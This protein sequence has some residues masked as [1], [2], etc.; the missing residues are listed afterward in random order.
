LAEKIALTA[1]PPSYLVVPSKMNPIGEEGNI[2]SNLFD[3]VPAKRAGSEEDIAGAVI[4]LASRAGVSKQATSGLVHANYYNRHILMGYL[5]ALTVGVFSL[6]MASN[7][8]GTC[9]AARI[10][11]ASIFLS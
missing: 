5:F 7:E 3:Q 1:L 11:L 10:L 2:F 4:Y 9:T 6:L 8:I